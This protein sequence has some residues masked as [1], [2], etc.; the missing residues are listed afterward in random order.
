M[1][2]TRDY[3]AD[4][5]DQTGVGRSWDTYYKT[6]RDEN[7]SDDDIRKALTGTKW[8]IKES[9]PHSYAWLHP[10]NPGKKTN[11]S[12]IPRYGSSFSYAPN[13]SPYTTPMSIFDAYNNNVF[14]RSKIDPG[15][16]EG[17]A[18]YNLQKA[19]L[20]KAKNNRDY[21]V[22]DALSKGLGGLGKT[23]SNVG[24]AFTGGTMQDATPDESLWG[25]RNKELIKQGVSAEAK[26]IGG[27]DAAFNA[28]SKEA[29]IMGKYKDLS[30][31]ELALEMNNMKLILPREYQKLYEDADNIK[32]P[33]LRMAVR[34]SAAAMLNKYV[35]GGTVDKADIIGSIIS[36]GGDEL[37]TAAE[38]EGKTVEDYVADGIGGFAKS[39]MDNMGT[40][41]NVNADLGN[42][43]GSNKGANPYKADPSFTGVTDTD[44]SV[45]D[46]TYSE[47]MKKYGLTDNGD[48]E[49]L[50][51]D[52]FK[53]ISAKNPK[54]WN[55]VNAIIEMSPEER[56]KY[57][58][59][60]QLALHIP[61]NSRQREAMNVARI[62]GYDVSYENYQ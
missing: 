4:W 1:A 36:A 6:L 17:S 50:R 40:T 55:E 61:G 10:T 51:Q 7:M 29:D 35:N 31:K 42:P 26:N 21:M 30:S 59:D 23:V 19:E 32:N 33:L 45:D 43:F 46:K 18:E 44:N 54:L 11:L 49:Q 3:N 16:E 27:S 47:I 58:K 28:A 14:G 20:E 13:K 57:A 25:A 53:N 12:K 52:A 8:D 24:A 48:V 9:S 34:G 56:N 39:L 60:H 62:L 41:I 22:I 5:D 37:E 15:L 38:E 2:A